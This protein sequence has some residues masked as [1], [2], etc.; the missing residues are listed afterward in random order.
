MSARSENL[1]ARQQEI[2]DFIRST[3]E[4]EGR[5]PTRA[6]VCTAFGFRSPNAAETHLRAL[7]D[8]TDQA[9]DIALGERRGRRCGD[10]RDLEQAI[11]IQMLRQHLRDLALLGFELLAEGIDR[12]ITAEITG[13][14]HL[15]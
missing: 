10:L 15:A 8:G 5:P 1:T 14:L 11:G 9:G 13:Q 7:A 6:E 12:L 3:V 4:S 2:L